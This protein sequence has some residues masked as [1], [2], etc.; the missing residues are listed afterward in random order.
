MGVTTINLQ[1]IGVWLDRKITAG[2]LPNIFERKEIG[3]YKEQI[4]LA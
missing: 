2:E 1:D 3:V 4:K